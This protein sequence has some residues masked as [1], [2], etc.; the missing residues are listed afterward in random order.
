MSSVFDG[1]LMNS[2]GSVR[3]KSTLASARRNWKLSS[4]M[5]RSTG[6]MKRLGNSGV[7]LSAGGRLVSS[8]PAWAWCRNS[9]LPGAP[10]PRAL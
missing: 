7:A 6:L 9:I 2:A 3:A 4:P 8:F 5:S 10:P 1:A